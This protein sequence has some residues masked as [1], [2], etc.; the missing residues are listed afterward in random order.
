[1][2]I[3]APD[4]SKMSKRHGAVSIDEYF[5][6]GYTAPAINNYL[7]LLGFNPGGEQEI[8]SLEEMVDHFTLDKIQKGGA[9]FDTVR[10]DWFN[11]QYLNNF[12]DTEIFALAESD[13][14]ELIDAK[15]DKKVLANLIREKIHFTT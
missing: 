6:R 7:G 15:V 8:F 11:K 4:K 2:L 12:S 1:P 5:N 13:Y 14:P 10:L 9:V 3:L